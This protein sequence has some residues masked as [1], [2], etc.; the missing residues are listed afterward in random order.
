MDEVSS[1]D[2]ERAICQVRQQAGPENA[3]VIPQWLNLA[4]IVWF[5][6]IS[7]LLAASALL[8]VGD[9]REVILPFV[10]LPLP[11]TCSTQSRLG[12]DCPGCGLTRSFIH[13]VHGDIAA[14]WQLNWVSI[15]VFGYVVAQLPLSIAHWIRAGQRRLG[16]RRVGDRRTGRSR[17]KHNAYS[18]LIWWN[19]RMLIVIALLLATRWTWRLLTGDLI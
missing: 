12:I 14:A 1:P 13:I 16:D 19:E 15:F 18:T 5:G 10:N 6:G 17:A 2:Q 11:E 3:Q 4:S 8:S 9:D 7:F